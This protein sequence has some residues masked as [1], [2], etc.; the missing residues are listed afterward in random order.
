M[1]LDIGPVYLPRPLD[2]LSRLRGCISMDRGPKALE[3][4]PA[5]RRRLANW[6]RGWV[7]L[8]LAAAAWI[9]VIGVGWAVWALLG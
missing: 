4:W 9:V 7:I 5:T 2:M 6:S 3:H 1:S 8:G